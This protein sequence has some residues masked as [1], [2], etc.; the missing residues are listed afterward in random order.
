MPTELYYI[1]FCPFSMQLNKYLVQESEWKLE[2][3]KAQLLCHYSV[4]ASREATK[5]G[6]QVPSTPAYQT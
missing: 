5:L 6:I 2:Q 1:Q 3:L 4:I